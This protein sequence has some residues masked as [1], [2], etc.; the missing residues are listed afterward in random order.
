LVVVVVAL[1]LPLAVN[2]ERRVTAELQNAALG[3]AQAIASVIGPGVIERASG[4]GPSANAAIRDLR[5]LTST[6]PPAIRVV[7][8]DARGVL[9][10]DSAG[11]YPIGTLFANGLRPEIGRALRGS[12]TSEIRYSSTLRRDVMA[13]AVPVYDQT[14]RIVGTVRITQDV[15]AVTEGVWRT[16]LGLLAI[17][18]AAI[19][20]G[21]IVA[22]GLAESLSRPLARLAS[23]AKR[24]GGGDL[25]TR[26]GD[27]S[28][29]H[30]IDELGRAFDEMADRLERTVRA[31]REFVA[32]A[33]HQLRTP[34]TAMKL[35]LEASAGEAV[36]PEQ[37][38]Q[39]DAAERE[40]DRLAELVDRLLSVS[41]EV[42]EG[43]AE[44]IDLADAV[45]RAVSRWSERAEASG[46]ALLTDEQASAAESNESDVDQILDNL[47]DN[48][49]AYAPGCIVLESGR[50]DGLA[51][52]AVRD[53]GPG[54]S[55]NEVD[56][57]TERFYR[58]RSAAGGGSGLG[59]AI[60]R[61]LA[62]R[63]G[64]SIE[65]ASTPAEGTRVEVRLPAARAG[66]S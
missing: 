20:A 26:V 6:P 16:R 42:E 22:F 57:V 7:V 11:V 49:I 48:A 4:P 31:Q 61:S 47:V 60:A 18:G 63:W 39:I 64:G 28:Q 65:I 43:R 1:G 37:R 27:V 34:L 21:L 41:R 54:I 40:V 46:A 13:T 52:V 50:R 66:W 2:L 55:A 59:L 15:E 3:R 29:A 35:R 56:R 8:T 51:F 38:K 45:E 10:A 24:L 23:A 44:R 58:G 30:E 25:T 19:L 33:S 36:N 14:G 62:E 17:G 9:L 5:R 32:N 12:P 53:E